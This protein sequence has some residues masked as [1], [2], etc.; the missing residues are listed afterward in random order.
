[1][2]P[3][4]V[5]VDERGRPVAAAFHERTRETLFAIYVLQAATAAATFLVAYPFFR[6][7]GYEFDLTLGLIAGFPP[8]S[9]RGF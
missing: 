8:S 7:V 4:T 6:L 3:T 2:T 1:V 5:R 9:A